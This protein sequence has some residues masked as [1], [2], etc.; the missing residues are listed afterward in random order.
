MAAPRDAPGQPDL[1]E[2]LQAIGPPP[3]QTTAAPQG[4]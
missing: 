4:D 1:P 3:T 2:V